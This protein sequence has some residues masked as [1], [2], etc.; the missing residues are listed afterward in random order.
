MIWVQGTLKLLGSEEKPLMPRVSAFEGT[1]YPKGSVARRGADRDAEASFS[2]QCLQR[3]AS[4]LQNMN[5]YLPAQKRKTV[6]AAVVPAILGFSGFGHIVLGRARC[7]V[8]ALTT[9]LILA[10]IHRPRDGVDPPRP[11]PGI[12]GMTHPATAM[13]WRIHPSPGT[14]P[15]SSQAF[16]VRNHAAIA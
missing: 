11:E 1:A 14:L 13:P 7:G 8:A 9:G 12:C 10:W 15:E 4:P 2:A 3:P 16:P 6:S 5:E